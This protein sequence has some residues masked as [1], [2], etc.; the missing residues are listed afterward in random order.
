MLTV[1]SGPVSV[2]VVVNKI[3]SRSCIIQGK[4]KNVIEYVVAIWSFRFP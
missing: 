4:A 1:L 2:F 3:N